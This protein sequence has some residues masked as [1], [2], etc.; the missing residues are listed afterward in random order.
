MLSNVFYYILQK[1]IVGIIDLRVACSYDDSQEYCTYD[2]PE[3]FQNELVGYSL[4]L[5]QSKYS[6][7]NKLNS[8]NHIEKLIERVISHETIHVVIKKLEGKETSDKLDDLEIS[9]SIWNGKNSY[10]KNEFPRICY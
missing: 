9:F 10:H 1:Y 7:I 2:N 6:E 3:Y 8:F 4:M 5:I